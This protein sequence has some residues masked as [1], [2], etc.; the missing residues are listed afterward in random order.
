MKSTLRLAVLSLAL[1]GGLALAPAGQATTGY[2]WPGDSC[3]LF[4]CQ[5]GYIFH[6]CPDL[7]DCAKICEDFES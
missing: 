3:P 5:N 6:C 1:A 2:P 4:A 7:Q